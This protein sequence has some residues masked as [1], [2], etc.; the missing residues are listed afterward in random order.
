MV[1]GVKISGK[2][3]GAPA[4]GTMML[5]IETAGGAAVKLTLAD[6]FCPIGY[7]NAVT[8]FA[9][10]GSTFATVLSAT[11]KYHRVSTCATA[12]D[13]VLLTAAIANDLQYLKNDGI[14]FF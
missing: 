13:S 11:A 9:T 12:G 6:L 2:A 14:L 10:G 7:E 4:V 5:P 1:T 8:A 3:S